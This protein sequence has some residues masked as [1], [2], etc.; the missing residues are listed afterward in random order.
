MQTVRT[1]PE[2]VGDPSSRGVRSYAPPYAPP[3]G[4]PG[5]WDIV[6]QHPLII[7]FFMVLGTCAGAAAGYSRKQAYEASV[8][9]VI[10]QVN[11]NSPNGLNGYAAAAPQLADAYS[12]LATSHDVLAAVSQKLHASRAQISQ[13]LSAGPVP[14]SPVFYLHAQAP[15]ARS[16]IMLVN[17][18]SNEVI[19]YVRH[20]NQPSPGPSAVFAEYRAAAQKLQRAQQARD[21]ALATYLADKTP[22]NLEALTK[23]KAAFQV[24]RVR[25]ATLQTA[26]TNL[27]ANNLAPTNLRIITPASSASSNRP[28]TTEK[29][30]VI[31]GVAGLMFGIAVSWLIGSFM[32]WRRSRA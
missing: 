18:A 12:R 25:T 16:A 3:A 20:I 21:A 8:A 13:R 5:F 11:T 15:D 30:A 32:L 28:A 29:L 17:A 2:I 14:A 31:G 7:V 4:R 24:A 19:N 22:Q 23:A 10:T 26:Y 1:P 9:M 6:R 27:T